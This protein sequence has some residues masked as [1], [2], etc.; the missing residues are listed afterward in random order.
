MSVPK[1][2]ARAIADVSTGTI[3]ATVDIDAPPENVFRA[4]TADVSQWWGSPE[5]Y[6][7]TS[8]EADVR[9]GGTWTSKGK[10]ADGKEFSVTGEFVAIDAPHLLVQTWKAVWD[11]GNT[12][13]I[14]Y[15]LDPI[16]TG[17]RVTLRHD[18]FGDRAQSCAG[19]AE[20]WERVLGWLGTHLA[21]AQE[22]Q[23]YFVCR[24]L[25]PRP[26]FMMDMNEDEKKVMQSH[27]AY[28]R[29]LATKG[30]AVVFGPVLD[31]K[32]PHGIGILRVAS[33]EELDALRKGDPA[34]QSERGFAYEV[35]PMVTAVVAALS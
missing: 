35:A 29:G 18:G 2:A 34:I 17:T 8:Y 21:A 22:A 14:R 26:S 7:V 5:T 16:P 30:K 4:L 28:W 31:P 9:V 12:T 6:Q 23:K 20:G 15:Q 1:R 13:T 11:G 27:A 19:H 32:Q 25:P 3:L 10:G 24:L 33:T